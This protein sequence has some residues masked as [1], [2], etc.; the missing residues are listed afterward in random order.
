M[1]SED[2]SSKNPF[3]RF[4]EHIDAH[5]A[6]GF[7][8]ALRF[9][10]TLTDLLIATA[11][12]SRPKDTG[13][14]STIYNEEQRDANNGD[15][16]IYDGR[17][18]YELRVLHSI[19][20]SR[21]YDEAL[22]EYYFRL[23]ARYQGD[24]HKLLRHVL[25]M[26]RLVAF[27][28]SVYSPQ[29]LNESVR[30]PTPRDIKGDMDPAMFNWND[31]FEDL[32]LETAG[33]PLTNIRARYDRNKK[34]RELY[35]QGEPLWSWFNRLEELPTFR[36]YFY[37][38][39]FY[40]Q[41]SLKAQAK[42]PVIEQRTASA[43]DDRAGGRTGDRVCDRVGGR[44][45]SSNSRGLS[46]NEDRTAGNGFFAEIEKVTKVLNQVLEDAV[47]GPRERQADSTREP[48]TE[49][50]LYEAVQSAFNEGQRSLASFFKSLASEF[51]PRR[52]SAMKVEDL[53]NGETVEEDGTKTVKSTREYVD[54]FG[55]KHISTE[56]KRTN[57]DGTSVST[58]THY[59]V[60]PATEA[61]RSSLQHSPHQQIQS[62]NAG[63]G[64]KDE[65]LD[66]EKQHSWFWK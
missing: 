30:A 66:G 1:P 62:G 23:G 51:E 22:D 46:G 4:K 59:S 11:A 21:R 35:P 12:L 29:S 49:N 42:A 48:R 2:D 15:S 40:E 64:G 17:A 32:L 9:P 6:A 65:K 52:P 63:H 7:Q 3:V 43:V 50:D 34:L 36:S 33:R 5:V 26:D 37:P 28:A 44:E 14:T 47:D 60:R 38:D 54:D 31:P 19:F 16:N 45:S 27:T 56:I 58:E 61:E 39:T 41:R 24:E 20:H 53:P 18:G 25:L 10:A 13:S 57:K 55:N 8:N